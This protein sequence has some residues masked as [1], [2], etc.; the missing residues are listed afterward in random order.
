MYSEMPDD[1]SRLEVMVDAGSA[2]L[3]VPAYPFDLT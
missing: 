3:T 1:M 2:R